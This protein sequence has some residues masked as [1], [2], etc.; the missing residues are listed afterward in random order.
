MFANCIMVHTNYLFKSHNHHFM[1]QIFIIVAIA[2]VMIIVTTIPI[3][4]M[5][6]LRFRAA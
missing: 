6:I 1:E 2:I 5:N 4:K 3:L